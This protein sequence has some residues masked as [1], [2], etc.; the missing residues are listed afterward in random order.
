MKLNKYLLIALLPLGLW[1]CNG[2]DPNG[3]GNENGGSG[4]GTSTVSK[5]YNNV[6]GLVADC[7]DPYVLK[8]NDRYYLYG[9]GG[10]DGIKCYISTNLAVWTDARGA[11]DGY[12]LHKDDVF[13]E[14]NFWAPEVYYMEDEGL[15]YMFY[16]ADERISVATAT[17][18][19]GPFK[20]E[21]ADQ[22][23]FHESG[24]I[25]THMFIDPKDGKKYLYY[26]RFT[27]GNE[28]WVAE[29][30]DD[31]RSVKEETLTHCL[32]AR[33]EDSQDWEHVQAEVI[34]G[35]FVLEH[36]G[37][38]YL[39]YSANH[40]ES[41]GYAVGYATSDSPMGPWTR[42]EGNPILI[43]NDQLKG[44]GHHS[45]VT[46][47]E[48]CQYIVYH[49]HHNTTAVQPRKMCIDTYEFVT[50]PNGGPDILQVNGPT[51]TDQEV[52]D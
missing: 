4:G 17:R 52:C 19:E 27:A 5:V 32:G 1:A 21:Q 43:G 13:G 8:Y 10:S 31:M 50:N 40:F 12:A 14:S 16:S 47:S 15:F 26:V 34:E 42:Y 9:T 36:N 22:K 37:T 48:G 30:A 44:T 29:L 6:E 11:T 45:F 33:D 3:G 51:T 28:I 20:Q 38:Y 46:K 39:T 23:P 24:E 7:A 35:P 25:D 41:Q 49:A 18:P 2:D